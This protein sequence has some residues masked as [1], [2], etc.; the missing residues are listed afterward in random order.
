MLLSK[1]VAAILM[2]FV[3][4]QDLS[5]EY[6]SQIS[7]KYKQYRDSK[8]NILNNFDAPASVLREIELE[9]KFAIMDLNEVRSYGLDI[10]ETW[11]NCRKIADEAVDYSIYQMQPLIERLISELPEPAPAPISTILPSAEPSEPPPSS[12][13]TELRNLW[14]EIRRKLLERDDFVESAKRIVYQKLF[15]VSKSL[16]LRG[17]D[18]DVSNVREIVQE[19]LKEGILEHPD[20]QKAIKKTQEIVS[21][22]NPELSNQVYNNIQEHAQEIFA[23]AANEKVNEENVSTLIQQLP[24]VLPQTDVMVTP[25]FLSELPVGILSSLK[26]TAQMDGYQWTIT[27]TS[28]NLSRV[29]SR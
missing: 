29:K 28:E 4:A 1:V 12:P 19:K 23:Q 22:G 14:G 27:E 5:N 15:K 2:D 25:D 3:T 24:E 13:R 8:D 20:L 18:I 16:F 11:A 26:I 17:R 6:A 21:R 9:L 10:E 7:R